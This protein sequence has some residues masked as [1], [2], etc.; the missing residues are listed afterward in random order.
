MIC[1]NQCPFHPEWGYAESRCKNPVC[2]HQNGLAH[3]CQRIPFNRCFFDT[4]VIRKLY[5]NDELAE[6]LCK[7]TFQKAILGRDRA[8]LISLFHAA[9]PALRLQFWNWLE[10]FEP[11]SIWLLNPIFMAAGL[12]PVSSF[13]ASVTNRKNYLAAIVANPYSGARYQ[14][15]CCNQEVNQ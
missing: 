3:E 13:S 12:I 6:N 14:P 15:V 10:K 4:Y 7:Y 8:L 1:C 11:R 9:S 5:Q 2:F